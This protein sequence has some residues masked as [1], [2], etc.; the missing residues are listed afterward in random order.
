MLCAHHRLLC[1]GCRQAASPERLRVG[2]HIPV[3]RK[4]SSAIECVPLYDMVVVAVEGYMQQQRHFEQHV[5]QVFR[6]VA[7]RA[8]LV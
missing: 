4:E 1:V 8:R 3:V 2:T 7:D 5:R 6:C